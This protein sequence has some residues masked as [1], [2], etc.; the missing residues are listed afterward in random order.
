VKSASNHGG[1]SGLVFQTSLV[2][3]LLGFGT[4][5]DHVASRD[6]A[7]SESVAALHSPVVPDCDPAF[8][9]AGRAQ[10]WPAYEMPDGLAQLQEPDGICAS[11]LDSHPEAGLP[12]QVAALQ[13][14]FRMDG[15]EQWFEV[16]FPQWRAAARSPS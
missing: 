9:E 15:F 4:Y 12:P 10:P 1:T 13:E 8:A 3:A 11:P 5:F 16:N 2:I 7:V 6:A 14:L